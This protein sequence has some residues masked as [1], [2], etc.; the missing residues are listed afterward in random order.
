MIRTS[1]GRHRRH[2]G[3]RGEFFRRIEPGSVVLTLLLIGI[4]DAVVAASCRCVLFDDLPHIGHRLGKILILVGLDI[5]LFIG[6]YPV[7]REVTRHMRTTH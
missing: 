3:F 6:L 4:V 7:I 1:N 2:G 5:P